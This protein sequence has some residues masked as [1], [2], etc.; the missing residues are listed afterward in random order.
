LVR[1]TIGVS[2]LVLSGIG[3]AT[4]AAAPADAASSGVAQAKTTV[5]SLTPPAQPVTISSKSVNGSLLRG[6][7]VTYV[8]IDYEIPY[9]HTV[10]AGLSNALSKVGATLDTCDAASSPSTAS[11]CLQTAANQGSAAVVV[12]SIPPAFAPSGFAALAAKKIPVIFL[13]QA[14][15]QKAQ[16][17]SQALVFGN[18]QSNPVA[19]G[20]YA[21]ATIVADSNGQ[22]NVLLIDIGVSPQFHEAVVSATANILKLCHSCLV[23]V[24]TVTTGSEQ[25]AETVVSSAMISHPNI[26][27]ISTIGGLQPGVASGLQDAHATSKVRFI[28][29]TESLSAMQLLQSNSGVYSIVGTNPY[30]EGWAS[31]DQVIRMVAK[32][33]PI[34]SYDIPMRIFTQ[35]NVGSL[36][37]NQQ[38]ENSPSWYGGGNWEAAFEKSW[39]A[40]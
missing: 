17:S 8:P 19:W 39:G 24:S 14:T 11:Q 23:T 27:Y 7:T 12:N 28:G 16:N 20:K 37:L 6:K 32:Q 33:T 1:T 38:A 15:T 9:F 4:I 34:S 21:A 22:A 26:N 30:F 36:T 35:S 3:F 13:D 5:K 40:K 25:E 18:S 2:A 29:I 31:A 10:E